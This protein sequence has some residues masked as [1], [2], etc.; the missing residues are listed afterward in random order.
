MNEYIEIHIRLPNNWMRTLRCTKSVYKI[1][2]NESLK[3]LENPLDA[4]LSM[5]SSS[6][7]SKLIASKAGSLL[8]MR[9]YAR[10]GRG[11]SSNKISWGLLRIRENWAGDLSI[12]E[13]D[14]GLLRIREN[15]EVP[16]LPRPDLKILEND[17]GFALRIREKEDV[18][19]RRILENEAPRNILLYAS[20]SLLPDLSILE[21]LPRLSSSIAL[22][23]VITCSISTSSLST[24]LAD[25]KEFTKTNST[26]KRPALSEISIIEVFICQEL[27]LKKYIIYTYISC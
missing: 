12:L 14:F 25:V 21:K 9:V 23:P 6:S 5:L 20:S 1:R 27:R 17:P 11:P 19:E 7:S 13:N 10:F 3:I 22:S 16:P 2:E 4:L 24:G 8:R 15:D 26:K 18:G